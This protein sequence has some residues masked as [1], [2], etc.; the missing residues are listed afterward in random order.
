MNEWMNE[1]RE[2]GKIMK[3]LCCCTL[4]GGWRKRIS[5]GWWQ[6][7]N[8]HYTIFIGVHFEIYTIMECLLHRYVALDWQAL[9]YYTV[10]TVHVHVS[11]PLSLKVD[12]GAPVTMPQN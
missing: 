3:D 10:H 11:K 8:K 5:N 6:K 1:W 9:I 7:L 4:A 12:D 2:K